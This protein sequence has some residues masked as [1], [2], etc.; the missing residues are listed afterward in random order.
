MSIKHW[1]LQGDK[2]ELEFLKEH[3]G[4]IP[5]YKFVSTHARKQS[6]ECT[7]SATLRDYRLF[8]SRFR[9][10]SRGGRKCNSCN[11]FFPRERIKRCLEC[12]DVELCQDC[13]IERKEPSGHEDYHIMANLR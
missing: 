2:E 6:G 9:R 12:S 4:Y 5:C 10:H 3:K 7:D 13:Y 11:K 8:L 1:Y